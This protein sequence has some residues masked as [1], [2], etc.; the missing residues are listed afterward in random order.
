MTDA[1]VEALK[2][3]H[4][5]WRVEDDF[6]TF[7]ATALSMIGGDGALVVHVGGEINPM[8]LAVETDGYTHS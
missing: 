8:W 4:Q 3:I 7:R 5:K 2:T 6:E 1:Q